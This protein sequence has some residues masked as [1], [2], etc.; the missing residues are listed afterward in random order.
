MPRKSRL[1]FHW[2]LAAILALAAA[3]IL[4][5]L[6][7]DHLWSDEGDTA[8]LARNIL[9]DGVPTAWDGVT[10]TDSDYGARLS[11][12]LVMVS[13]PWMQY[14]VAAA[15]FALLGESPFA[16]RL[17]FALLGLLTIALAYALAWQS[18]RHRW[19]SATAALLLT[20]SVQFLLYAR[21]SR[22]YTLH[23]ALT[24]LLLWQFT[25]LRTWRDSLLFALTGIL[26]FHSHPIGLAPIA[27][28]GAMA[29]WYRP[30]QEHRTAYL[31]AL[32][33]MGM[34]IVPWFALA[35]QGYGEATAMLSDGATFV[36]R[37]LQYLVEVG[38]VTSIVGASV[39]ALSLAMRRLPAEPGRNRRAH[40][41]SALAAIPDDARHLAVAMLAILAA[42]GVFMAV[43]Q[44]RDMIWS[45][46]VRYTP[47]VLPFLAVIVAVLIAAA[48]RGNWRPWLLM[49][50][51]F[52]FTKVGRLTPW[53]FWQE[54]TVL[55]A[56][57]VTFHLPERLADRWLRTGQVAYVESLFKTSP[58]T[59]TLVSDFLNEHAS[60][61]DVVVTNYGWEPLYFHTGLRQGMSV[62][63]KYPVYEAARA[64]GLP[65]YV[66][67]PS[68]ARWIVWRAA[69][70]PYRG[71][72]L[73]RLL[74][75]L[76][77]GG[78]KATLVATFP[79]TMWENRENIH[80]R[81]FADGRYIYPWYERVPDT[82]VFRLDWPNG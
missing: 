55:R 30:Y 79:E 18:T 7:R 21:Q 58:G 35:R 39:L 77:A 48:S 20:L 15:A 43:T 66:F 28:L 76:T 82:K 42:Y 8:V 4:P 29:I 16:A 52:G 40:R 10:F 46:G 45:V 41:G 69:W 27:V 5:N 81:R 67:S 12:D 6:G 63:P 22:H 74:T 37:M 73:D 36:P 54:P 25:S 53:T 31:R 26:L 57:P 61:D 38:S 33:I 51:V 78:V 17:P 72:A 23:A 70:G 75:E 3:L 9:R 71:H 65:D 11:P 56:A 14:Y 44:P 60:S 19:T 47:A 68:G 50:L 13:S 32:P 62:L 2:P 80:F 49:L 24:C 1:P 34:F 59:T 64:K